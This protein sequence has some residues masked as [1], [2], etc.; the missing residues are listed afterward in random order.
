M[1]LLDEGSVAFS[2]PSTQ[3]RL[4]RVLTMAS[5][6]FGEMNQGLQVGTSHGPIYFTS[7]EYLIA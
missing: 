2:C 4:H 5:I 3:S 1:G 7:G 6:S